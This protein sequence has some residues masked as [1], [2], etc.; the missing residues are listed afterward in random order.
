MT[1]MDDRTPGWLAWVGSEVAVWGLAMGFIQMLFN[2]LNR[3]F[4]FWTRADA[5]LL[6]GMLLA[7]G[8]AVWAIVLLLRNAWR[9]RIARMAQPLFFFWLALVVANWFPHGRQSLERHFPWLTGTRY[10]L[11]VWGIGIA[12]SALA[13]WRPAG[14]RFARN[15][16]RSLAYAWMLPLFLA[17]GLYWVSDPQPPASQP[18]AALGHRKGAVG[19]P[20][21]VF[22]VLDMV[23]AAEVVDDTGRVADDLP[24][25]KSFAG[26]STYHSETRAP[27]SQT[28]TSLPG[29]CLQRAVGVPRMGKEGVE[30]PAIRTNG[31]T[32]WLGTR[33]FPRAVPRCVR[34][35]GGRS[36]MCS[37]YLP[38]MD[39]FPAE[40]AWNAASTHC[41]YGA[42]RLRDGRWRGLPGRAGTI[43]WQWTQASK[44]PLAGFLKWLDAW[45]PSIRRYYAD[46][47]DEVQK[48]GGDFLLH[49]LS[50]GDF[51]LLHQPLP[52]PP[53]AVDAE[54]RLVPHG[55]NTAAAYRA[56]LRRADTLFGQ[57][58]D[59]L[60]ASGLWDDSWV[61]LTS[62]HGL[63]DVF[64]SRDPDRHDKP[65]V[66]LWVKAPGQTVPR[67][68]AA[69]VRLDN[70][71]AL[72]ENIWVFA[73]PN[74][75]IFP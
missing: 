65:H 2:D 14:R 35:G 7:G 29:I 62:D 1:E 70:L 69:P 30:W 27:G 4:L 22:V 50:P 21:V 20:P 38:W 55:K 41:F 28:L 54:G 34:A 6:T 58:M 68:D 19:E 36:V 24:H 8:T 75:E 66:P 13:A 43:L 72:P 45:E 61:I 33:S 40:C 74:G 60:R 53:F 18:P 67:V 73:F 64:W 3:V 42:G 49:A 47:S 17:V 56:Q 39:W 32:E 11:L 26:T 10:Y 71:G 16:W 31:E 46:L 25:L 51:A 5:L 23:A 44:T 9:G 59:A 12:L 63:H 57:W 48:E 37:Y 15:A 52:H